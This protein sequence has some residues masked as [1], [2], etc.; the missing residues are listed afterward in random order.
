MVDRVINRYNPPPLLQGFTL[1]INF[2]A[3]AMDGQCVD[4]VIKGRYRVV[5]MSPPP[6]GQHPLHRIRDK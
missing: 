2:V 4:R 5:D 6:P 1:Y 3:A